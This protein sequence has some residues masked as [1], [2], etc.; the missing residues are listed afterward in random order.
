MLK[1]L[2]DLMPQ[3]LVVGIIA[4]GGLSYMITGPEIAERIARADHLPACQANALERIAVD[5]QSDVEAILSENSEQ[6]LK[7]QQARQYLN[8]LEGQQGQLMA[9]LK[10]YNAAPDLEGQIRAA[11][12]QLEGQIARAAAAAKRRS[13]RAMAEA[14]GQCMCQARAAIEEDGRTAWAL[15]AASFGIIEQ[16]PVRDFGALMATKRDRCKGAPQ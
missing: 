1:D 2:S 9:V 13:E 7:I 8:M 11:E 3:G 4:Y 14:P 15:Y 10:H 6:A 12:K 16:S 5:G